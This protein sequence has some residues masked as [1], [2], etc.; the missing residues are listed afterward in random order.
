VSLDSVLELIEVVAE[1][2]VLFIGDSIVDEYH[3]V[4]PLG[5]SAKENLIP[6][7]FKSREVFDG[8]VDAAAKHAKSFVG[9][10][11]IGSCGPATRKVRFVDETYLRKGYEVHYQDGHGGRPWP[12]G[13]EFDCIVVTDFGHGE[14]ASNHS[15]FAFE[16]GG[17]FVAVSAQTNSA[18]HGFNLITKYDRADYIVI[19]E[20]EARLA[21]QD[22]DSPLADVIVKLA[23]GR[24][25][26]F[27]VTHGRHGAWGWEEGR[28]V[29]FQ[30]SFSERPVDTMGAGDAFFAVTAPM[31]KYGTIEDLLVIGHAAGTLKTQI[32]GHRKPVE[33]KE[34]VEYLKSN[35]R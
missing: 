10:V 5:K 19:D 17:V 33:K 15:T 7:R 29:F 3:Y 1:D 9:E 30:P 24:S 25:R 26:K 28:G 22:R 11:V 21:A 4:S 34:L 16:K 8:G 18:N 12:M 20:P 27:I 35:F 31:A 2:R 6:V 32:V 14:I 23:E 13:D